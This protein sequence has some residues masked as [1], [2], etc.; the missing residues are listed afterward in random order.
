MNDTLKYII[1]TEDHKVLLETSYL[2]KV[3]FF[4]E[5]RS[6]QGD[7]PKTNDELVKI[8]QHLHKAYIKDKVMTNMLAYV[9]AV[10]DMDTEEILNTSIHDIIDL[11]H[12]EDY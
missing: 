6:N 3:V 1:G 4:G 9:D 10:R 8:T 7:K 2:S 12:E 11:A 5:L